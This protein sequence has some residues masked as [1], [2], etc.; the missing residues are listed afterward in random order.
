MGLWHPGL[1]PDWRIDF[2]RSLT[3]L[4]YQSACYFVHD[5]N[6]FHSFCLYLQH[7]PYSFIYVRGWAT[8][9]HEFMSIWI[10][11]IFVAKGMRR[12][13]VERY[14]FSYYH[15]GCYST[16]GRHIGCLHLSEYAYKSFFP[17]TGLTHLSPQFPDGHHERQAVNGCRSY[18][19]LRAIVILTQG[20]IAGS[21]HTYP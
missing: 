7:I 1:Y 6:G 19:S 5:F 10:F 20:Y 9:S 13:Q 4:A 8:C 2:R 3:C 21:R 11:Y 12:K 14:Q 17:L 16:D 15:G 18:A